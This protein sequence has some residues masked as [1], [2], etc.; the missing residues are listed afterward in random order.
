LDEV[1]VFDLSGPMAHFRK[2]YTNTSALSYGFPPRTVLMGI[3][4]AVLGFERDS[5]YESLGGGRFA[6]AVKV[7]V[8]RLV[9]TV[10]YTRTKTEDLG[11]LRRLGAVP[12]TQ[13]P[14]EFLLP[15]GAELNL[16]F[17]VF[18]SHPDAD[19]LREAARRCEEQRPYYPL[20]LGLTECLAQPAFVRLFGRGEYEPLAPGR[21]VLLTSVLNA[22]LLE[23]VVLAANGR[24]SRL[25]RER[26]PY[27]FGPGRSLRPPVSVIYEADARPF[28]ARLR[29][30]VYRFHL[31][32]GDETE[33]VAFLEG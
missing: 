24:S 15:R 32:T 21:T 17:R 13:V 26:A 20:Y 11:V 7:P 12:G 8:R 3:V 6:V 14:L 27:A 30:P 2:Y 29:V 10:N 5:Y 4:A 1:L 25:V 18:F 19:L 16:R 28:A 31:S 22:A 23:E 9:Q 33:T